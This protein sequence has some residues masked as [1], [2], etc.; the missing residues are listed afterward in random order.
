MNVANI[1]ATATIHGLTVL[2]IDRPDRVRSN[3]VV[4]SG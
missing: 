4:V 3:R 1:T 2:L